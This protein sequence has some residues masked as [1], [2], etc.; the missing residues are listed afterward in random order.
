[1]FNIFRETH[2]RIT[3]RFHLIPLRAALTNTG[4]NECSV[5]VGER[6]PA[7]L[8]VGMSTNRAPLEMSM[9]FPQESKNLIQTYL[10]WIYSQKKDIA[11]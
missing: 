10:S 3:V 1:M 8:L 2:F 11:L 4:N 6:N 5:G 7:T 9:D